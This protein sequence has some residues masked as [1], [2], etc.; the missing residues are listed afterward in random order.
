VEAPL[1]KFIVTQPVKKFLA[2]METELTGL[3]YVFRKDKVRKD[4][5]RTGANTTCWEK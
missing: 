1:Q 2:F 4:I 3:S 5:I